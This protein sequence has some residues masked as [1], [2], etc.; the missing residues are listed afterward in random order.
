MFPSVLITLE[1]VVSDC[2]N[3]VCGKGRREMVILISQMSK[4]R[5]RGGRPLAQGQ[6][7]GN[8]N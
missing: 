5:L 4:G 3:L 2:T 8:L 6:F 7:H 1:I